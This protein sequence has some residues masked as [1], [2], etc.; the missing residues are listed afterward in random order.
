MSTLLQLKTD[1]T[2]VVGS[3]GL[4]CIGV[5]D[6]DERGVLHSQVKIVGMPGPEFEGQVKALYDKLEAIAEASSDI[7]MIYFGGRREGI[8]GIVWLVVELEDSAREAWRSH[9]AG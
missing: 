1:L 7:K 2:R 9:D 3:V 6:P 5:G 8:V 4:E